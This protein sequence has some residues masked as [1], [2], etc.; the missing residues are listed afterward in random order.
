MI[1]I[2]RLQSIKFIILHYLKYFTEPWR[3]KFAYYFMTDD[4]FYT[5]IKY[6]CRGMVVDKYVYDSYY[7]RKYD[8]KGLGYL[9]KNLSKLVKHHKT[10]NVTTVVKRDKNRIK[11]PDNYNIFK[12]KDIKWLKDYADMFELRAMILFDNEYCVSLI[13]TDNSYG[14]Y[15][16][17]EIGLKHRGIEGLIYDTPITCDIIGNLDEKDVE[18]I[19]KEVSELPER[20]KEDNMYYDEQSS[21]WSH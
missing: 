4:D 3:L 6:H 5:Y 13:S 1:K 2:S 17:Y 8:K 21:L 14:D 12:F 7:N 19:L 16:Q 18:E 20:T 11:F 9:S 15:N 10:L